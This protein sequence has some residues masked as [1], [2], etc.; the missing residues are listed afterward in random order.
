MVP[1]FFDKEKYVLHYENLELYLRLEIKK[2]HC[3]L[4]FNQSQWLK[5]YVEFNTKKKNRSRKNGDEDGKGLHKLMGSA[6]Y[7]KMETK[8]KEL[9]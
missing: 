1:N 7:G 6:V 3:V 9:I 4:E 5:I 8:E 2:I